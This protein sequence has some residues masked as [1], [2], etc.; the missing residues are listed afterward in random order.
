VFIELSRRGKI[1]L[2]LD[3]FDEMARQVD[4]QTVVDNF[5]ELSNLATENSKVILTSRTEYFRWAEESTK[6][7]GGEEYGRRRIL[8]EPPKFEVVYIEPMDAKRIREVII[9]RKGKISG[10]II[11][12][13]ILEIKS[14]SEMAQKPV[15]IE[16]LL[17]ALDEVNPEEI[18]NSSRVYLYATN[19]LLLRNIETKRTFTKTSDKLFFL[20]ELAWE[21]IRTGELRIHYKGIPERISKYFGNRVKDAHELDCW[22]FDLRSQTML[23]RDAAGYYE[24]AHK[25]LAEYFVAFKFALELGCLSQ[26]YST[27]YCEDDGKSCSFQKINAELGHLR[28]TFGALPLT[29][30][31]M[32]AVREFILQII[33]DQA[34]KKLWQVADMTRKK[35]ED[36]VKFI[37]GNVITLL[38]DIGSSFTGKNLSNMNLQQADLVG[39]DISGANFKNCDLRGADLAGAIFSPENIQNSIFGNETQISMCYVSGYINKNK[40][41]VLKSTMH[42]IQELDPNIRLR[43]AISKE[44]VNYQKIFSVAMLY[45]VAPTNLSEYNDKLHKSNLFEAAIFKN[46][47]D[48][49]NSKYKFPDS[50]VGRL[51]ILESSLRQKRS[52]YLNMKIV[53][54]KKQAVR[55]K[56]KKK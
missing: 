49:L 38:R 6:I 45:I 29:D 24:F 41:N 31:R 32:L 33:D 15:L 26:A 28:G 44:E 34:E 3:G 19:R 43:S 13:K 10:R 7:L 27:T 25:S 37:G 39:C 51:F 54:D 22:D 5:W 46:D 12:K 42:L 9:K 2:I 50:K 55:V 1:L 21:M 36:E 52:A 4:Y 23:H 48:S 16:L 47:L 53:E 14:L 17:A 40:E 20:C 56:T 35:Q 30:Q 8:L 11:A 18:E